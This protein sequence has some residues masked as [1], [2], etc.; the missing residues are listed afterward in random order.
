MAKRYRRFRQQRTRRR[1]QRGYVQGM[2]RFLDEAGNPISDPY[3]AQVM[4]RTRGVPVPGEVTVRNLTPETARFGPG[5]SYVEYGDDPRRSRTS[6]VTLDRGQR[7]RFGDMTLRHE[8]SHMYDYHHL[9]DAARQRFAGI[10][11]DSRSWND[12]P[13]RDANPPLSELFAEAM[14][15]YGSGYSPYNKRKRRSGRTSNRPGYEGGG[16]DFMPTRQQWRQL[17]GYFRNLQAGRI[18]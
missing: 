8:L 1:S 10:M 16:Y 13:D 6:R 12:T 3:P 5:R 15:M 18:R 17:K 4:A 2:P 11:G 7:G 14:A 9:S